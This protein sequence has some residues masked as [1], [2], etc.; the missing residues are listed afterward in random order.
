MNKFKQVFA[1]ALACA[2][3]VAFSGFH[4]KAESYVSSFLQGNNKQELLNKLEENGNIWESILIAK[5]VNYKVPSS[6]WTKIL[7]QDEES[8]NSS[9]TGIRS[10]SYFARGISDYIKRSKYAN[11][12]ELSGMSTPQQKAERARLEKLASQLGDKFS[13]TVEVDQSMECDQHMWRLLYGYMSTVGEVIGGSSSVQDWKP[14]S[15]VAHITL[16]MSAQAKDIS[17]K[18]SPDG[19]EFTV[20]GPSEIE[21]GDWGTKIAKGIGRG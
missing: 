16:V 14:K 19:K 5:Y 15:G 2:V 11:L 18:I 17:V 3:L 8:A 4:A 10:A 1:S 13:F 9:Y 7:D 6:C 20:I 21:L 12:D